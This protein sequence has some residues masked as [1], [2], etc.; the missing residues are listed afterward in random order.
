MAKNAVDF[1][2]CVI[3]NTTLLQFEPL[4]AITTHPP[5]GRHAAN[6]DHSDTSTGTWHIHGIPV[7][8]RIG[9]FFSAPSKG[10]LGRTRIQIV[11][12]RDRS[13]LGGG[14]SIYASLWYQS[15]TTASLLSYFWQIFA[16]PEYW[17]S[18]GRWSLN[19][20]LFKSTVYRHG[21]VNA[22]KAKLNAKS[23][24]TRYEAKPFSALLTTA[25]VIILDD[26]S[27]R[28]CCEDMPDGRVASVN[29]D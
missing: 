3:T 6:C 23:I 25:M 26:H 11:P 14:V 24:A 21:W 4:S 13:D 27:C 5:N 1:T 20:R 10:K 29:S 18:W 22:A 16:K 9:K 8:S 2:T 15:L 28:N 19:N 12:A 7:V 17:E